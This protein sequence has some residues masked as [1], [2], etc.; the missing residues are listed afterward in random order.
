VRLDDAKGDPLV[1][2]FG[3]GT[4]RLESSRT[5]GLRDDVRSLEIRGAG[6]DRT[7]LALAPGQLTMVLGALENFWVHDLTF[8]GGQVLDVRGGVAAAIERVRFRDCDSPI[9]VM[10]SA[11]L[12]VCDCEFVRTG[13]GG[14]F[15]VS[16]RGDVVVRFEGCAFQDIPAALSGWGGA[17]RDSVAV[18]QDCTFD[19]SRV[20]DSRIEHRGRPEY[21]IHVRGGRVLYGERGE[22]EEARRRDWGAGYVAELSGVAFEPMPPRC[23]L[24]EMLSVLGAAEGVVEGRVVGFSMLSP[25]RSE[26]TT[27]RI[28]VF[29]E[30]REQ[31]ATFDLPISQG[32]PGEPDHQ[33]TRSSEG[34]S[35]QYAPLLSVPEAL[36]R[37]GVSPDTDVAEVKLQEVVD[38]T[39][40]A[41]VYWIGKEWPAAWQIDAATGA[42]IRRP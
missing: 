10:G 29:D 9:L 18:F 22:T 40:S 33:G 13:D 35:K 36:R 41:R 42:V 8:A 7:T 27:Y 14:S 37:A 5:L 21:P 3:E 12:A 16:A 25:R 17:A 23:T 31:L 6:V 19:G 4:F 15:A 26:R 38:G 28:T 32:K 20:A 2:E 1:I 24:A 11:Y 34:I 30:R 39:K